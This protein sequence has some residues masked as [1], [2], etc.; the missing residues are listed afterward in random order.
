MNF[1]CMCVLAF[2]VTAMTHAELSLK[3]KLWPHLQ[4]VCYKQTCI[5]ISAIAVNT[6]WNSLVK[7]LFL[8]CLAIYSV[9]NCRLLGHAPTTL[10]NSVLYP[11]QIVNYF[12]PHSL[13]AT[14]FFISPLCSQI[15]RS[16]AFVLLITSQSVTLCILWKAG[17]WKMTPLLA[18]PLKLDS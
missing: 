11:V 3:E 7:L 5:Q 9:G 4:A 15:K 2:L 8:P 6:S 10:L 1:L 16:L 13:W 18:L 14:A 12:N 17:K